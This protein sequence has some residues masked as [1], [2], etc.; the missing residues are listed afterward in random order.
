MLVTE[1]EGKEKT[2]R[3]RVVVDHGRYDWMKRFLSEKGQSWS[4]WFASAIDQ[5]RNADTRD[6][7]QVELRNI[8]NDLIEV[9]GKLEKFII[10]DEQDAK[11][12]RRSRL[13]GGLVNKDPKWPRGPYADLIPL[14]WNKVKFQAILDYRKEVEWVKRLNVRSEIEIIETCNWAMDGKALHDKKEELM[15]K[16]EVLREKIMGDG[17]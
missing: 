12:E 11:M 9:S 6:P 5:L 15:R 4:Q 10:R 17:L 3:P 16:L 8:E 14:D 13:A 2:F 1:Q 7:V